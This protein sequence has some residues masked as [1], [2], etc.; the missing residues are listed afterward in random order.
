MLDPRAH[1][2]RRFRVD[3]PRA[4]AR[5][6]T[7]MLFARML[8]PLATAAAQQ[9]ANSIPFHVLPGGGKLPLLVMGDGVNWG[10]GTNWTQWI[11]LVGK[12]AGIDSAW[13]YGS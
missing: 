9:H 11:N 7:T 13:D 10:R 12:G 8:L 6:H 4:V 3:S 5:V 1:Q 2:I